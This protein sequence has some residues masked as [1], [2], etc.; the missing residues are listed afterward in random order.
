MKR[1]LEVLTFTLLSATLAGCNLSGSDDGT[2]PTTMSEAAK[3]DTA[4]LDKNYVPALFYSNMTTANAVI[5]ADAAN[6]LNRT[7][8]QWEDYKVTY[9]NFLDWNSYFA[10]VDAS[11]SNAATYYASISSYPANLTSAHLELEAIRDS[12]AT[13]R[14]SNGLDYFFDSV[15][16]AH[17]AMEPV[18][19]AAATYG[20]IA[21]PTPA[22]LLSL[23]TALIA[24]LPN[25]QTEWAALAAA[26]GDGSAVR[27]L[28]NLSVTKGDTLSADISN[29]DPTAPGM[30]QLL[31][32]LSTATTSCNS[33]TTSFDPASYDPAAYDAATADPCESMVYVSS[34]IKGKF[35]K[36][37]LAFGDFI[38]P[39]MDD[40]I[41]SNKAMIPALYCTG[42]P[43]NAAQL[44]VDAL[45]DP[46]QGTLDYLM[47]LA[48]AMQ[49]F[50]GHFPVSS[51]MNLPGA[52]GWGPSMQS[53]STN[54]NT[55][56][57]IL[58]TSP[59]LATAK[60]NG[61]HDAI[62]A[63][64]SAMHTICADYESQVTL[65]TRTNLYHWEFEKVL[66]V[67]MNPD[68]TLKASL[69]AAEVSEIGGY[70]AA[71]KEAFSNMQAQAQEDDI[72][73]G[74]ADGALDASLATQEAN[75]AAL[76]AEL[77]LYDA[78]SNDNSGT[79]AAKSAALKGTF[80]PYFTALG[81]F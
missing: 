40:I 66:L 43:P 71:V 5:T 18:A 37:F 54:L 78:A 75:I 47:A 42:N 22:D 15:T 69:S 29:S 30:T 6:T 76:E 73:W 79:I 33:G 8:A 57:G 21:T 35:V 2:S 26:Y 65:M 51:S 4:K 14:T 81:A 68:G 9:N 20:A 61:A 48:G 58:M 41:A 49:T 62:E 46:V 32:N 10:E 56:I 24:S 16:A 3:S 38:N 1:H 77:A 55:A 60:A 80:I 53:A 7:Q 74:L 45:N 28:Y 23:Q 27:T 34:K 39:F 50:S 36:V 70:M 63:V 59:D 19:G 44:C 52:L 12:W 11:I 13:M 64:R 25:F 67:V 31:T 17:H 72:R